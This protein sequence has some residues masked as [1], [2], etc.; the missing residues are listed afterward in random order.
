M[1]SGLKSGIYVRGNACP[2]LFY[3][4]SGAVGLEVQPVGRDYGGSVGPEV[5]A[6][7][8]VHAC[9]KQLTGERGRSTEAVDYP[10][11]ARTEAASGG[12]E[13]GPGFHAVYYQWFV[14]VG[15]EARVEHEQLLLL[16]ERGAAQAVEAAFSYGGYARVRGKGL[17]HGPEDV[18]LRAPPWMH[19]GAV[20]R[21]RILR[22]Q[23]CI[24]L[25]VDDSSGTG[26]GTVGVDVRDVHGTGS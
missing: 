4:K 23:A 6:E 15:G 18:G 1:V 20:Q 7:A 26:G 19:A 9:V 8:D 5:L 21:G 3:G 16:A 14:H 17:H 25:Y 10:S 13:F 12:K 11:L 24:R 2:Y 22:G